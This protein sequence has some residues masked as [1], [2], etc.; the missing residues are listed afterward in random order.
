MHSSHVSN[1]FDSIAL[2]FKV[3]TFFRGVA[4]ASATKVTSL[5]T[6][7][8]EKHAKI[9]IGENYFYHEDIMVYFSVILLGATYIKT[10]LIEALKI[11]QNKTKILFHLCY[12]R[13]VS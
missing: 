8:L 6:A 11:S 1:L 10:P 5:A 9:M 7:Q 4:Y 13:L 2:W 12:T 3:F